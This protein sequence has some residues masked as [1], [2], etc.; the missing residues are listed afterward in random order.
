MTSP[1]P[2]RFLKLP[3][4][5]VGPGGNQ[6]QYITPVAYSNERRYH[7]GEQCRA[8]YNDKAEVLSTRV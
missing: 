8:C 7:N 5:L 6:K 3:I 4:K 2:N 1:L